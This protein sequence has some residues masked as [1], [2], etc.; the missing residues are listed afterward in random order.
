MYIF[1]YYM[2]VFSNYSIYSNVKKEKCKTILYLLHIYIY[3][4]TYNIC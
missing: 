2:K 1:L 4:Y 3:I